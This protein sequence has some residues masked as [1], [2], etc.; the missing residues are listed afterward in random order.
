MAKQLDLSERPWVSADVSIAQPLLFNE[1]GAVTSI[2]VRLK[3]VGRSMALYV[4][5]WT[6]LKVGAPDPSEQEKLCAVPKAPANANSD[7]GYL[8]FPDQE[9]DEVQPLIAP[10]KDIEEGVKGPIAGMVMFYVLVCVDYRSSFD[11]IH[12]QTRLVRL[13]ARPD[14]TRGTMMGTFDPHLVYAQL[15]LLPRQHGDSAD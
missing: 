4:S 10:S 8:V 5:V 1:S 11:P 3:N 7:Y 6:A 9:L 2:R 14:P 12:H 13:L 15:A